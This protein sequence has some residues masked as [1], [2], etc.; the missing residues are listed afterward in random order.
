MCVLCDR[1]TVREGLIHVLGGGVSRLGRPSLPAPMGV[2][3]ALLLTPERFEELPGDHEVSV[4][5]RSDSGTDVA[6]IG[7][8]FSFSGLDESA[9]PLPVIPLSVPLQQVGLADYGFYTVSVDYDGESV[10]RIRFLVEQ[11]IAAGATSMLSS[12]AVLPS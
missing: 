3:L 8:A 4:I 12:A 2:D 7:L 11:Q 6:R 1:A 5:V 10:A 9:D